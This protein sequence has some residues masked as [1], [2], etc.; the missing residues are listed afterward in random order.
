MYFT[1]EM[2]HLVCLCVCMSAP[3]PSLGV[4]KMHLRE[5]ES[6]L[7]QEMYL[8]S[9]S[10]FKIRVTKELLSPS[11]KQLLTLFWGLV[12]KHILIRSQTNLN[13]TNR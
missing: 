11:W 8:C 13:K 4:F 10:A 1:H 2:N 9:C 6:H 7:E 12:L 3:S 5:P